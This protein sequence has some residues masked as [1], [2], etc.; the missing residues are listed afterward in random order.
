MVSSIRLISN[1]LLLDSD[2]YLLEL[3]VSVL[4][5]TFRQL[6]LGDTQNLNLHKNPFQPA[7]CF[8]YKQIHV[9]FEIS[10]SRRQYSRCQQFTC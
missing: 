8:V 3:P 2:K 5:K 4:T 6:S 9:K 10:G 7:V 1:D